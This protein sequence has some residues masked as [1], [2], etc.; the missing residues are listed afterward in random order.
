[1]FSTGI[2]AAELKKCF[3]CILGALLD[4]IAGGAPRSSSASAKRAR[5]RLGFA[6]EQNATRIKSG[7]SPALG[8]ARD[9]VAVKTAP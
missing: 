2:N 6:I 1:M 8:C 7:L 5:T 9:D 3:D 4:V